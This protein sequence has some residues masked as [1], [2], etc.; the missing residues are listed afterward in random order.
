MPRACVTRPSASL[1]AVI[2]PFGMISS[3]SVDTVG[4]G[5][6]R[7][8]LVVEDQ[9]ALRTLACELL[10][11]N[12]WDATGAASADEA[13]R[14]FA[15]VDPDALVTDIDLGSRPNGIDLA[16]TLHRL[17]PHLGIV[18]LS[19]FPRAAAGAEPLGVAGAV[20]VSKDALT[21][22]AVLFEALETALSTHPTPAPTVAAPVADK[23]G[24]LTRHQIDVLAMIA[25]G[26]SNEQIAEA[27]G[28]TVRAVERSIS[29]IFERMRLT[30]DPGVNPRV[31]AAAAYIS[32][33]GPV[34]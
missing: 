20:F 12:G 16:Q 26:W 27:S 21:S 32:A 11:R 4:A 22:P 9:A 33:F 17:A 29:R 1:R 25:R 5:W 31:A 14:L 23:L 6:V 15:E 2:V 13:M 30:G 8:V 10:T 28:A 24:T 34:R 19:S 3:T 18:F 7:R